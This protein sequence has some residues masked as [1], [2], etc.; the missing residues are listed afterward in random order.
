MDRF[1][2]FVG[3]LFQSALFGLSIVIAIFAFALSLKVIGVLA[4]VVFLGA[5]L[6]A[7]LELPP[8]DD[9]IDWDGGHPA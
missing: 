6:E 3:N 5:C 4:F 7:Y 2:L 1:G 9:D 8:E